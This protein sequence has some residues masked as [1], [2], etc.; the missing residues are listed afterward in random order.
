MINRK[1]QLDDEVDDLV[2]EHSVCMV[3]RDEERDVIA[4]D[5][6]AVIEV[7]DAPE[8]TNYAPLPVSSSV[9]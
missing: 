8:H 3:V 5:C 1:T 4:L 6:I 9:R 2:L 7:Y